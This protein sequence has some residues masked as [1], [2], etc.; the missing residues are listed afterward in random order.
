MINFIT[1]N[2]GTIL[3]GLIVLAIVGAIVGNM[4]KR[5]KAGKPAGCDCGCSGCGSASNCTP[6]FP[7]SL[8]KDNMQFPT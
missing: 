8:P 1:N 5:T 2:W 6:S 7:D 4:I 3:V